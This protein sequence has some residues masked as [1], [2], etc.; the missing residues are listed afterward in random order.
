M[1]SGLFLSA[2]IYTKVS[3]LFSVALTVTQSTR[4]I[5]SFVYDVTV[6]LPSAIL[7]IGYVRGRYL[8]EKN[9]HE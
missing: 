4:H 5:L 7:Q 6:K 1:F 8:H 2:M 9:M 3:F